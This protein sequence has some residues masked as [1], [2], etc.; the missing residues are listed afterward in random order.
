MSAVS[1]AACPIMLC[2]NTTPDAK[3]FNFR[4]DNIATG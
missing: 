2:Q 4:R 3:S 1:W